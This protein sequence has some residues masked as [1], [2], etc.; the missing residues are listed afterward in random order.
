ML[1]LM[2]PALGPVGRS[3]DI[4]LVLLLRSAQAGRLD[5]AAGEEG[6]PRP[7]GPCSSIRD[8][9]RP[10]RP[11][12]RCRRGCEP[13]GNPSRGRWL[14]G[15]REGEL[16]AHPLGVAFRAGAGV[17]GIGRRDTHRRRRLIMIEA[18]PSAYH[19]GVLTLGNTTS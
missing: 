13:L 6:C 16:I 9:G 8:E 17:Q 14:A 3:D 11:S 18:S 4:A 15:L 12:G 2:L 7:Q 10:H 1:N 19:D 5:I